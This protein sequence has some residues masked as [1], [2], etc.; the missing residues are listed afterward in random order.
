MKNSKAAL[1]VFVTAPDQKTA[2][3]LATAVLEARAAACANLLPGIESH[4][5]W[6]GKLEVAKEILLL[7]K[8]NAG[9][10]ERLEEVIL[11]HHPYD[12]P[13]V[14]ALPIQA[15]NR[16]YLKWIKASLLEPDKTSSRAKPDKKARRAPRKEP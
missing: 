10:L 14:I 16:R 11:K 1:V 9:H 2:R 8:T 13:E 6:K 5:W 3:N 7:F 4:Y 15:G 12:T